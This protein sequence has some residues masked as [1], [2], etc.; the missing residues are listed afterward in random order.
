[1]SQR[2]IHLVRISLSFQDGAPPCSSL[3]RLGLFPPLNAIPIRFLHFP[4]PQI[5]LV[6]CD[7]ITKAPTEPIIPS[8][9]T[10]GEDGGPSHV[11]SG[12]WRGVPPN[13]PDSA[14]SPHSVSRVSQGPRARCLGQGS[15]SSCPGTHPG[16]G[17]S[18]C[19]ENF[20][21]SV[22][23]ADFLELQTPC[24]DISTW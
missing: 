13:F 12:W 17:P 4:L 7:L 11:C 5:S 18:L 19:N 2:F 23:S 16:S 10:P 14:A 20:Q 9:L 21:S 6:L 8:S 3:Q 22:Y 1:M 24:L 15:L